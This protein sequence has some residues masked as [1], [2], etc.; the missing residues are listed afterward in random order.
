MTDFKPAEALP[1]A[2]LSAYRGEARFQFTTTAELP[3]IEGWPG[4]ERALESMEM[5]AESRRPAFNL[6]VLGVQGTGRRSAARAIMSRSAANRPSPGDWVYVSR[7]DDARRPRALALPAGRAQELK[8]GVAKLID[9]L[10]NDIPAVFESD[11]YQAR[12]GA[13]DEG[14][15]ERHETEMSALAEK[16][17][18]RDVAILRTPMGFGVAAR[19]G[20][21]IL[22]PD[23]YEAL[24]EE[25]R[26]RIDAAIAEIREE[27]EALLKAVPKQMKAQRDEV[28][29]LNAAVA[30]ECV[31]AAIAGLA[32]A[33]GE[34]PQVAAYLSDL[35]QDLID[36][37]ELFLIREDA[38]QAGAFPV[39]MTQHHQKPQF[40]R[41]VVNVMVSPDAAAEGAPVIEESLPSLGNLIGRIEYASESGALV[42]NFTMIRPGALH[43]AN[44]GFLI[45]DANALL[46]EP[47]AWE[48]LKRSLRAREIQVYSAGERLS[49]ISTASLEPDPIPLDVRIVLIGNRRLY[50]LLSA[51]DP[52]F[53]EFF[54][55]EA[56]FDD[57]MERSDAALDLFAA[58]IGTLAR[59]KDLLAF[60]AGGAERM[61]AEATRMADD[62][63]RLTL[64]LE[65]LADLATQAD[66]WAARDG[67]SA[68]RARDIDTAIEAAE[69]RT[70][71]MRE[72][73]QEA[74]AR[75][76][77][78]I[79]TEGARVGQINGLAVAGVG[80]VR[81]GKPSRITVRTRMGMGKLVDIEREI[82]L[83]G[84]L[85][86]KGVMILTGY[87]S[88]RFVPTAPL[89]LWASIVF[90]QSYGEVDGDS[91]SAAELF[92]LLSA[93]SG[94]AID[95]SLAVTG[96]VNQ[97]G[98][99]QAI[100]GVNQK[101]EGFF[102]ICAERGLTGTQGVLIPASNV[103]NLT[104]R[105]RVIDAVEAG[106]FRII[107]IETIDQGIS[108]LTGRKPGV[109]GRG[110]K[111]PKGSVNALVEQRL[112]SY[113]INRKKFG[114]KPKGAAG[115]D[116]AA[117][118]GGED[119][120]DDEVRS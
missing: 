108:I 10:A 88:G 74:V 17:R 57:R 56:D 48:A 64:N 26:D 61:L 55:I 37:A 38:A 24:P 92:A 1:A 114:M 19:K 9:D 80:R 75:G 28:A 29:A 118:A 101:I 95:Q 73:S 97:F 31:S 34:V 98:D 89:A 86:S 36:N 33:F 20:E 62:A 59:D 109:R 58:M 35:R 47:L 21:E 102:D 16:A 93:L 119:N 41:Y 11:D 90:E 13:I 84:P 76:S 81:F 85:H 105:R 5:A 116:G 2:L 120:G 46:R 12:R 106:Q 49:L 32:E 78:L 87:L 60:D 23:E 4:Q 117:S 18:A 100:G 112:L 40:Q 69:R 115:G 83:G 54:K 15:G 25:Q 111:F 45:L 110:G 22:P 94:L 70:G 103:K 113:A 65:A 42:T 50:F 68:I 14:Y 104:L 30:K 67:A 51:I 7:F 44:G 8:A 77:R 53:R 43:R 39:A 66:H 96:S 6:F 79:A 72:M 82:K 52:E 27:L 91:A 71:R 107:P 3:A 63:E 99:V